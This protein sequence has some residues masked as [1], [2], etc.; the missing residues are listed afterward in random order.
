VSGTYD[1]A[2]AGLGAMGGAAAC[3]LARRGLKV[4]G[5]DRFAPP[6]ELGSS[7]GETRI[8]RVAYFEDPRYVPLVQRA[9][10][11]W[12]ELESDTDERLLEPTGGLMI[13]A[14]DGALVRGALASAE[15]HGLEHEL[16]DAAALA[17][18]YPAH[19]PAPGDVAVWEPRAGVLRPEACVAAHLAAARQAGAELR[20]NE[21]VEA[22]E[23]DGEGVSVRTARGTTRASQLVLAAGAW[24]RDLTPGLAVPLEVTR[25]P[26]MWFEPPA[27]LEQFDAERFPIF[28]REHQPGRFVYGFPRR[29]ELVKFAIHQE[30]E[31]T[32]PDTVRRTVGDDEVERLR[33]ILV[34]CLPA[35]AGRCARR[36][37]CLYTNTPDNHF[38]LGRHPAHPAVLVASCCSGHGFKFS[39]AIGELLADLVTGRT[40]EFDLGLFDPARP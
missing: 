22:W 15:A 8:I 23:P 30:G 38:R 7:H 25:Q 18:R 39:S 17:R 33:E 9:W 21:P 32:S 11:L 16:L 36:S 35:A 14:P 12:L 26:L 19:R 4:I 6:H 5:F 13:G 34:R 28:I 20:T 29:E 2:V 37:V 10:D 27:A 3:H 40:P 24:L 1:V 31:V